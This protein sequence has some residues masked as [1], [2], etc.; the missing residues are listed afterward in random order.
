MSF[1]PDAGLYSVLAHLPIFSFLRAP[2]RFGI[3]AALALSVLAAISVTWLLR[4]RPRQRLLPCAILLWAI[5]DLFTG[6]L[7]QSA[8]PAT[9]AAHRALARMPR[10]PVVELPFFER[11]ID[12]HRHTEFMLLSTAHWQPLVNG[13]SDYA[14]PLW[15]ERAQVLRHFP[16]GGSL[17][18]A[19][20]LGVRYVVL[21]ARRF[22][23]AELAVVRAR[24]AEL[25]DTLTLLISDDGVEL[26]MLTFDGRQSLNP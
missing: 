25:G 15:V 21:H 3:G 23:R 6:P 12:F 5:G 14:S 17:E 10:A 2:A 18:L 8:A 9:P 7:L 20:E 26:Y 11:P 22:S 16:A 24:F 19:R 13:Y 4:R 1:G